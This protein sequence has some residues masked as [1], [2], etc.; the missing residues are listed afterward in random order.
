MQLTRQQL[1]YAALSG[2]L[3]TGAFPKFGAGWLAWFAMVPL[4]A[5]IRNQTPRDTFRLGLLTG[6]VHYLTLLYWLAGTMNTYGGMSWFLSIPIL[7]LFSFYLA[8]Y[9]ALFSVTV[10]RLIRN[11]GQCL[12]L[13]PVVWV[14]VEYLRA[15][16]FTGFPWALLGH[17]QY[18]ALQIIQISD[19]FGVYG[20]S[21]LVALANGCLLLAWLHLAG[22]DWHGRDIARRHVVGACLCFSLVM[23][24]VLVYGIRQMGVL[25]RKPAQTESARIAV[26][27]GN[28]RQSDKWDPAFRV[29]TVQKYIDLSRA[30]KLKAADLIV[31]PETATPFYFLQEKPFTGIIQQVI[32][33]RDAHFLIGSPSFQETDGETVYYNSAYL[34]N[35]DGQSAG[36]Y[37]KAHLV[38]FGEYVPYGKWLPFVGKIV[39]AVGDF[40]PGKEGETLEWDGHRLGIQICY[41]MVFPKLSRKMVENQANLLINITNDA[42]YGR[43]SA[44]FQRFSMTVF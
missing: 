11:P 17:S 20:V 35:P 26:I 3:L 27:Q 19:I 44:P 32:R 14:A 5:S 4:L 8:L 31:W 43:S 12:W 28:I 18:E 16:L 15:K 38:P 39:E 23:A 34:M 21:G 6:L 13:L 22:E 33:S 41:E 29:A 25:D 10:G 36:K 24:T 2:L 30:A 1:Y 9:I 42:W 37:S 40:S 7:F